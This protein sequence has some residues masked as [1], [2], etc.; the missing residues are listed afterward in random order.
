MF[1]N[2]FEL[3]ALIKHLV[4]LINRNFVFELSTPIWKG[5]IFIE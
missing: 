5:E 1:K 2:A 3:R 4:L